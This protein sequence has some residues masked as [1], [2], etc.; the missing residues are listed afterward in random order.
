MKSATSPAGVLPRTQLSRVQIF[1]GTCIFP[2]LCVNLSE[3]SLF[4]DSCQ[5]S[6]VF[7]LTLFSPALDHPCHSGHGEHRSSSMWPTPSRPPGS[8]CRPRAA[9]LG[10]VADPELSS[11]EWWPSLTWMSLSGS[12]PWQATSQ[13]EGPPG[14]IP[15]PLRPH[16]TSASPVIVRPTEK[17]QSN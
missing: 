9:L 14:E 2:N 3:Q 4:A 13:S 11:G 16:L 8:G 15:S 17:L 12:L 1:H 10:V 6:A 7:I 5:Q